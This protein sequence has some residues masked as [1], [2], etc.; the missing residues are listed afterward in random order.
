MALTSV[1]IA[2]PGP[3]RPPLIGVSIGRF[4]MGAG[5]SQARLMTGIKQEVLD[6]VTEA[7]GIPLLIPVDCPHDAAQVMAALDG[8]VLSGGQD[9][10]PSNYGQEQQV[11][12]GATETA[13][14]VPFSRPKSWQPCALRDSSEL[15]LYR[16]AKAAELPVLG[17]CRGMQLI[18]VA[19]GGTLHQEI[20]MPGA[21][22]H[23]LDSEGYVHHHFV[24]FGAGTRVRDI[25]GVEQ[26]I[27]PSTH[28]QAIARLGDGLVACGVAEDGV[29]EFIEHADP[30]HFIVGVQGHPEKAGHNFDGYRA[31]FHHFRLECQ[32]RAIAREPRFKRA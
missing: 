14:G 7:G 3:G 21:I 30:R 15:A 29:P 25:F 28:H 8:L 23:E 24:R 16:A 13:T 2:L 32:R 11:T 22:S 4:H 20:L 31:L 17:I 6:S 26:Y 10:D 18:N 27:V 1:D 9:V 12:Y 19:E 5:T